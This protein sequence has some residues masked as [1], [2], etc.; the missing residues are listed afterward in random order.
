M[1]ELVFIPYEVDKDSIKTFSDTIYH[2]AVSRNDYESLCYSIYFAV[3]YDFVLYEFEEDY[4]KAQDY[5]IKSRDCLLLLMTWIYFMKQNH[6]KR[7]ATQV[8]PLNRVAMEL[9]NTDMD[10]YWLFCYE[11]LSWGS[12]YGQWR[13]MKNAGVSFI[14]K[15]VVDDTAHINTEPN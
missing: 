10:R 3:R 7:D 14:R 6:W 13:L 8:K 15:E 4:V 5:V 1:E 12:L 11:A 9:K 2:D